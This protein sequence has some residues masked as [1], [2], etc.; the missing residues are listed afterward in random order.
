MEQRDYRVFPKILFTISVLTML[1]VFVP[2]AIKIIAY[3]AWQFF[4]V[5]DAP[6]APDVQTGNIFGHVLGNIILIFGASNALYTL[7]AI[8][9]AI[10]SC[11]CGIKTTITWV[12]VVS[13]IMLGFF[14]FVLLPL[15]VFVVF[16]I[17]F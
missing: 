12:K 13:F 3:E 14:A 4:T 17:F 16:W 8:M 11:F 9:G 15:L 2:A 1:I 5:P 7:Y 6:I 10:T